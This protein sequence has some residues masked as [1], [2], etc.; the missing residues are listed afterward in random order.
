MSENA[1]PFDASMQT[2]VADLRARYPRAP[3]LTLG[4]T[5]L[6]DEP[7]KA[8]F[9]RAL[10]VLAP[11]ATIVAAV[12][13]TD[14]FAKLS[15]ADGEKLNGEK[16]ALLEHNDGDTRDL[17]SAAGEIS[18][19]FGSET[20]PTRHKLSENGVQMELIAKSY[21]GGMRELLNNETAAWGW[22]ALVHTEAKPLLAGEV[23]LADIAPKLLE[24]LRWAFDESL[25]CIGSTPDAQDRQPEGECQC[26]QPC[27]SREVAARV[28]RWVEEYSQSEPDA[29][30]SD[31][32]RHLTPRLWAMVRGGGS[33][34][35][36][37]SHSLKIFRFNRQTHSYPRFE[38]VGLFLNPETRETACRA[39]D[40]AVRGSGIYTLDQ[41]G[42]GALPF[43]VVLPGKGR[44]TLRVRE[45]AIF[46]ETESRLSLPIE[47][48]CE[49]VSQLAEIL[50]ARFGEDVVLVGKAVSLISM[51][52]REMI[53]V[54]HEKASGYTR[55]TQKMNSQM[56][57]SGVALELHPLL[58][59]EYSAWDSLQSVETQFVLPSHLARAFHQE[60]IAA[61]EFAARW[62][63]VCDEQDAAREELKA[64]RSPR[65][66]LAH[67]SQ[68][69]ADWRN[70]ATEFGAAREII[71]LISNRARTLQSQTEKLRA[72]AKT[73][74]QNAGQVE[75]DKGDDFRA[76][77]LPLRERIRDINEAA[78]ARQA[79]VDENGA[80]RKVTKAERAQNAELAKSE[81]TEIEKLR[82]QIEAFQTER[83]HYDAEIS[84]A[85]QAA[86]NLREQ[87]KSLVLQRIEM[88]KS[89]NAQTVRDTIARWKSAAEL[90]RLRRVR[91]AIFTAEGLRYINLRPTAWWLPMVSPDGKWFE[92]LATTARARVE[93]I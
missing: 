32:Y 45:N 58:R 61:G 39:Y 7:V 47:Q 88:E 54:F 37:T 4:Q 50:E 89:A 23:L 52:A 92:K 26:A 20:V 79:P 86:H 51:L 55:L 22:R 75:R 93:E 3:F 87:A 40:D 70:A 9:C 19:L 64:C 34:N 31:L 82:A 2:A 30:L 18:S 80:P 12:H 13:D 90:E 60:K 16:F 43:D 35:L 72:D 74:I 8:A 15:Q 28:L 1:S 27:Q 17:W 38:F 25:R 78:A 42:A 44:G 48:P 53:F 65:E 6:W 56:R 84:Q 62:K 67:L 29:T 11:E 68:D 83:A 10:E 36:Q 76:R 69:D 57:A 91:D 85:R 14:Y 66:L 5:V 71:S 33:C 63:S 49:S 59:L 77:V 46:I 24:Q 41:F 21:P 73:Q 81:A